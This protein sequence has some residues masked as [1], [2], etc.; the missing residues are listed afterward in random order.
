MRDTSKLYQFSSVHRHFILNKYAVV[1]D[2]FDARF[3]ES[4]YLGTVVLFDVSKD[5]DI[6]HSHELLSEGV[7]DQYARGEGDNEEGGAGVCGD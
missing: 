4:Y 6:I 7:I 5:S 2:G 3:V 1:R